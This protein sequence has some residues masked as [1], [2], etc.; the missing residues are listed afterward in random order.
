MFSQLLALLS[1][2]TATELPKMPVYA[3]HLATALTAHATANAI[4]DASTLDLHHHPHHQC[5]QQ[6]ERY[7]CCEH[8]SSSH[9][10][11]FNDTVCIDAAF[12]PA[13]AEIDLSI[14]LDNK[15]VY[16]DIVD[17]H[18]LEK[19]CV[20]VPVISKWVKLCADFYNVTFNT[21]FFSACTQIEADAFG[22]KVADANLGCFHFKL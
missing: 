20:G 9:I 10:I 14:I 17:L 7:T 15:T 18:H 2:P 11:K 4:A 13:K 16:E 6:P 22:K 19:K 3:D 5:V 12:V 8:I 21:S 1:A